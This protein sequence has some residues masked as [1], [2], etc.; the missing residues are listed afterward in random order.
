MYAVLSTKSEVIYDSSDKKLILPT[1][2]RR[3]I[4]G[5]KTNGKKKWIRLKRMII[6]T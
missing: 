4:L 5:I 3:G 1:I 2:V 6:Q